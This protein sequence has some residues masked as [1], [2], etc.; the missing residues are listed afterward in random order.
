MNAT[1]NTVTQSQLA[2]P[3]P[4][5]QIAHAH[6][7]W[8]DWTD[9]QAAQTAS[10]QYLAPAPTVLD[11][12]S[13]VMRIERSAASPLTWPL[14]GT[15]LPN[16]HLTWTDWLDAQSTNPPVRQHELETFERAA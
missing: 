16:A 9:Q 3:L 11:Q 13:A 5:T 12:N 14:A 10:A 7:T 8:A 1:I 6:R 2:W 15:Q 4:G